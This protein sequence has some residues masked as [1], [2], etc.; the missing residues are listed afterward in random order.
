VTKEE[1]SVSF[2]VRFRAA[3]IARTFAN[4]L[5]YKFFY[6]KVFY[7]VANIVDGLPRQHL[8]HEGLSL[9]DKLLLLAHQDLA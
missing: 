3:I 4:C 7:L 1:L 9:S 2:L 6:W 5:G 8:L